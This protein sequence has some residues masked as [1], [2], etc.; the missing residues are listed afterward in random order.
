MRGYILDEA[1]KCITQ[2]REEQYGSPEDSFSLTAE[3]WTIAL[4]DS[5]KKDLTA[6]DIAMCM[7]LFKIARIQGGR[8]KTDSYIDG[9][10][11]LACACEISSHVQA[12][13]QSVEAN[14]TQ[15]VDRERD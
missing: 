11:Y 6:H 9:C 5:L 10:G 8:F 14:K 12:T 3:Y 4:K 1:K 13:E 15:E 7:T 2:D